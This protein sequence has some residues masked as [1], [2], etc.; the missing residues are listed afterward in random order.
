MSHYF[1]PKTFHEEVFLSNEDLYMK[2][3]IVY[4]YPS[5]VQKK[6]EGEPT[7]HN[8]QGKK[9]KSLLFFLQQLPPPLHHPLKRASP[10]S[11]RLKVAEFADSFEP[12]GKAW[13][14]SGAEKKSTLL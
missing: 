10:P 1:R 9:E 12:W 3:K 8:L 2:L 4:T 11:P 7:T 13:E 5:D 6:I 14:G